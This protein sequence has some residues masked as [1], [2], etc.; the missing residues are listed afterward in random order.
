MPYIKTSEI[1]NILSVIKKNRLTCE[2]W[3]RQLLDNVTGKFLEDVTL[4]MRPE[5]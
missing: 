2:Y 3:R 4:K 5:N 1:K